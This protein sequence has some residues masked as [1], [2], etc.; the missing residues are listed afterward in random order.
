MSAIHLGIL[1]TKRVNLFIKLQ[2]FKKYGYLSGGTALA[3]QINHRRSF[4]FDIFLNSSVTQK[5]KHEVFTLFGKIHNV[6]ID[7][8]D[9]LTFTTHD[10]I[11]ITFLHYYYPNLFNLIPTD[12]ISIATYKDI[13]ADKSITIG[14]RSV[15]RDYVDLFYL[16]H[17]NILSIEEI[18]RLSKKKFGAEFS[19]TLFVQQLSYFHDLA[20]API[21]WINTP[22]TDTYIQSFLKKV[23]EE[24]V[25]KK[26]HL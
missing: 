24:Y 4:D 1:D 16:M 3:F 21:D 20:I 22:F 23:V 7:T 25:K 10:N 2:P 6:T 14:R 17:E 26:L 19:E 13:A 12:S 5:F 18:I 11:S 8:S 15:W 9:Q